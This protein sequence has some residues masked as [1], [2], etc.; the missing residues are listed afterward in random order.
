MRKQ[1]YVL[2][3]DDLLKEGFLT[4]ANA[5]ALIRGL[6]KSGSEDLLSVEVGGLGNNL[7]TNGQP[8]IFNASLNRFVSASAGSLGLAASGHNHDDRYYTETELDAGFE[9]KSS[10][11]YL[12]DWARIVNAPSQ[13]STVKL[14]V[15]PVQILGSIPVANNGWQHVDLSTQKAAA[16]ITQS[17]SLV[18]AILGLYTEMVVNNDN[19]Y[20]ILQVAATADASIATARGVSA[21]SRTD[22]DQAADSAEF[23]VPL[24]AENGFY[25]QL[26][27]ANVT[28][29]SNRI[30]L[31]GFVY[32]IERIT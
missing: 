31:L 8:I 26:R 3:F 17:A 4:Q 20:S 14:Y 12:V 27:T 7:F 18:A 9:G 28:T 24:T 30:T 32:N 2:D 15:S 23:M 11:K 29:M 16:G 22:N 1:R 10:G 6:N 19:A 13:G 5:G 21:L 25:Y